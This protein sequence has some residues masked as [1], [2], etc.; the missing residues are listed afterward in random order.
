MAKDTF[1]CAHCG[2]EYP[3]TPEDVAAAN[4][5]GKQ[6]WGIDNASDDDRMAVVCDDC[7]QIVKPPPMEGV[8][9]LEFRRKYL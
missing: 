3:S 6:L 2:N 1:K 8:E 7:W 5:E 4:E 9:L